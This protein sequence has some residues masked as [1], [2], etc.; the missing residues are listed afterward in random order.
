LP[1][2]NKKNMAIDIAI[3]AEREASAII[4]QE[5]VKNKV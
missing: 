2:A 5:W 1:K 4:L 3:F